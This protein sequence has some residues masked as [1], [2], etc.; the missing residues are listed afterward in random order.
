LIRAITAPFRLVGRIVTFGG[1]IQR[2][3]I[4][5]ARFQPGST[6]LSDYSLEQISDLVTL[7][8][9]KPRLGI[10]LTGKATRNEKEAFRRIRFWNRIDA[11]G[12]ARYQA[13]LAQVYREMTGVRLEPP[14]SAQLEEKA[15]RS[16]LGRI[17]VTDEELV[18]LARSRAAAVKQELA[19]RG[20]DQDRVTVGNGEV[21]GNGDAIVEFDLMSEYTT[22]GVTQ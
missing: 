7:L 9:E 17:E 11:T 4:D 2:L 3:R 19:K 8:R 5:P 13:A 20:I 15:E 6:D 18:K 12:A 14:L 10:K 16:V 22:D 1:R 21:V